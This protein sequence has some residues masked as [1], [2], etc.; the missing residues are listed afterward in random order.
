MLGW[1]NVFANANSPDQQ[2][3]K[4]AEFAIKDQMGKNAPLLIYICTNILTLKTNEDQNYTISKCI[5]SILLTQMLNFQ[6]QSDLENIRNSLTP[7]LIEQ[8]K[9]ALKQNIFSEVPAIRNKCAQCYSM[10]FSILTTEWPDGIDDV[11]NSFTDEKYLPYDFIGFISIM[12]EIVNQKNFSNF[13]QNFENKFSI[14]TDFCIFI[15]SKGKEQQEYIADLRIEA[16]K[17]INDIVSIYP[18]VLNDGEKIGAKIPILLENLS[19]SISIENVDLFNEIHELFFIIVWK[20]Y[21]QSPYFIQTIANYVSSGFSLTSKFANIC[22]TFWNKVATFEGDLIEK[23]Q[24]SRMNGNNEIEMPFQPFLTETAINN[25]LPILANFV[26]MIDENDTAAYNIEREEETS[27]Y[28]TMTLASFYR[29]NPSKVFNFVSEKIKE[30]FSKDKWSSIHSGIQFIYIISDQPFDLNVGLFISQF[31]NALLQAAKQEQVPR[32]R[33]TSL[34]VISVVIKNYPQII[35]QAGEE[36]D[37]RIGQLIDLI[38]QTL[39]KP[40]NLTFDNWQTFIRFTKIIS[41]INESLKETEIMVNYFDQFYNIINFLFNFGISIGDQI[42]I[43]D[44][45]D[46]LNSLILNSSPSALVKF[47][48]LFQK[49]LEMLENSKEKRS[50]QLI[51]FCVQSSF[52]TNIKEMLTVLSR[53]PTIGKEIVRKYS[54][55][56][57]EI[58]YELMDNESTFLY[59]EG[60]NMISSLIFATSFDDECVFQI[61][62]PAS[63]DKLINVFVFRGLNTENERDINSSCRV[64]CYLFN[65]LSNKIPSLSN[66]VIPIFDF[67]NGLFRKSIPNL[68]VLQ[69]ILGAVA[70]IVNKIDRIG[71][72]EL[73][74]RQLFNDIFHHDFNFDDDTESAN[75]F[76]IYLSDAVAGYAK[77]YYNNADLEFE[78]VQLILIVNLAQNVFKLFPEIDD[79]LFVAFMNTANQFA[80]KCSTNNIEML[81]S[82]Y[83]INMLNLGYEYVTQIELK[84]MFK[85]VIE[86]IKNK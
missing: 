2:I 10:L 16:C 15:L 20:F 83:V 48:E 25:F 82:P 8:I 4:Q 51:H 5:A 38:Q 70:N 19:N 1:V 33:E 44:S 27:M 60:L 35:T 29:V 14:T 57:V 28:A 53:Y 3:Q 17:F 24:F 49:T 18:S 12:R 31:F 36:T 68:E 56:T 45:N 84:E 7:E 76:Y 65:F 23:V 69:S 59:E 21:V 67:L 37:I 71:S 66:Y 32:L 80:S 75:Y 6:T 26:E 34:F 40:E 22:I 43:Q 52:L 64:I 11:V 79:D 61:F 46:S 78:K 77:L 47:D 72:L 63:L 62:N 39:S 13:F 9:N 86:N 58:I 50:S 73:P 54:M 42:L 81:N 55:K 74:L 85:N 30:E 41:E